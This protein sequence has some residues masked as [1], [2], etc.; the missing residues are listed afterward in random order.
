MFIGMGTHENYV[1]IRSNLRVGLGR[2]LVPM[3]TA[4]TGFYA[5]RPHREQITCWPWGRQPSPPGTGR[6]R[7]K[8]RRGTASMRPG[9][10]RCGQTVGVALCTPCPAI[11]DPSLGCNGETE[12]E[13]V[14][15]ATTL[16]RQVSPELLHQRPTFPTPL[17]SRW[18][19]A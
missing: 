12:L 11:K 13:Q 6:T 9:S 15:I 5:A 8:G 14:P 19:H 17:P 3:S 2:M 18:T 16:E 4:Q 10:G 1:A 7:V